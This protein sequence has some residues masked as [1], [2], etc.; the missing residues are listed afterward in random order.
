MH[1]EGR[2]VF[3]NVNQNLAKIYP[4]PPL[5]TFVNISSSIKLVCYRLWDMSSYRGVGWKRKYIGFFWFRYVQT[6][7]EGV[8]CAWFF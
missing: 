6:F 1:N 5:S 7:P 8:S 2:G 3:T 4:P